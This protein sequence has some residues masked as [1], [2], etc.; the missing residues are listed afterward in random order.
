MTPGRYNQRILDDEVIA[1]YVEELGPPPMSTVLRVS[2][3]IASFDS[4]RRHGRP[5][6]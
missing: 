3:L 5:K 4:V 2:A 6:Q 1:R